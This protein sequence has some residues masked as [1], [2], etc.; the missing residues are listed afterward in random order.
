MS[1]G[2]IKCEKLSKLR[3]ATLI[4]IG[5]LE[6]NLCKYTTYGLEIVQEKVLPPHKKSKSSRIKMF[7]RRSLDPPI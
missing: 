7:N 3:S 1:K 4:L 5:R 2:N 6:F